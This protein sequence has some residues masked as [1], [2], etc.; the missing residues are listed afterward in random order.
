LRS[1]DGFHSPPSFLSGFSD[2][3]NGFLGFFETAHLDEAKTFGATRPALLDDESLLDGSDLREGLL[4]L[5]FRDPEIQVP[6]VESGSGR[7][8]GKRLLPGTLASGTLFLLLRLEGIDQAK[9]DRLD[10]FLKTCW[11]GGGFPIAISLATVGITTPA[12][13]AARARAATPVAIS[14]TIAILGRGAASVSLVSVRRSL[15]HAD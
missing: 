11:L 5:F 14:T 6:Y 15:F 8:H 3:A 2:L 7:L 9:R 13:I 4:Q 1:P 12:A 10:E